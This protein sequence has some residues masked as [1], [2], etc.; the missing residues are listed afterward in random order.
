MLIKK[1]VVSLTKNTK[2]IIG[3]YMHELKTTLKKVFS[4]II[5]ILTVPFMMQ[6]VI[7]YAKTKD[8][9]DFFVFIIFFI[10]FFLFLRY[11]IRNRRPSERKLAFSMKKELEKYKL[12]FQHL[13]EV[14]KGFYSGYLGVLLWNRDYLQE[15]IE[16]ANQERGFENAMSKMWK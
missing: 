1:Y 11:L 8:F 14:E 15:L 16:N 13:N 3:S 6:G 4:V 5:V 10:P 2:I 7:D 9:V 12:N